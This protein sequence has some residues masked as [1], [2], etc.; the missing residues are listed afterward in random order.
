MY[1]Y[2]ACTQPHC[3]VPAHYTR[4][5]IRCRPIT[6]AGC[7]GGPITRVPCRPVSHEVNLF[8]RPRRQTPKRLRG[9][10]AQGSEKK[11]RFQV[12]STAILS[13][14]QSL[15]PARFQLL[16]SSS[17]T[18]GSE[19]KTRFQ[20]ESAVILLHTQKFETR[21]LSTAGVK[22]GS[23]SVPTMARRSALSQN[24]GVRE[25]DA[26]APPQPGS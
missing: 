5:V 6:R 11:N 24:P 8:A 12:E 22:P 4:S 9:V 18:E 16:G 17:H 15:K 10:V 23:T 21:A 13:H 14:N 25:P 3:V 19:R 7:G 2:R 1:Q 26:R 20:V